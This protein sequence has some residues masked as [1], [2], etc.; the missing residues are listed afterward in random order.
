MRARDETGHDVAQHQ[1]LLELL[2]DDRHYAGADQDQRQ[3]G[4]QGFYF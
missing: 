1:R 4:Y 3:V 2:E